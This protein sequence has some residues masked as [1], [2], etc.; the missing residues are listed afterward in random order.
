MKTNYLI[1]TNVLIYH[2][3]GLNDSVEFLSAV[4]EQESFH[5]SI[6]TKIE[7]LCWDKHTPDGFEKCK[8]LIEWA[9][10]FPVE[11]DIADR[12]IDIKWGKK[13]KIADAVITATA[14]LHNL[15]LVTRNINDFKAIE[16]IEVVNPFM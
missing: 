14:I 9:L 16:G 2:T 13:I 12:A 15:K 11:H 8:K 5:V 3:A 1:D 6:I 4:I 10:V 7:F